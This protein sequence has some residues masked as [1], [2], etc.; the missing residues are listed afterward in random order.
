MHY[1]RNMIIIAFRALHPTTLNPGEEKLKKLDED[2]RKSLNEAL[3]KKADKFSIEITDFS[4]SMLMFF[5]TMSKATDSM[6]KA[7]AACKYFLST[8]PE[9]P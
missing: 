5:A 6:S 8:K 1:D 7:E 3:L 4:L 2:L 9:E